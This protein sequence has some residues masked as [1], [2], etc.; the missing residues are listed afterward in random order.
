MSI[1][2]S[3]RG[4][5]SQQGTSAIEFAFVFPLL[6]AVTYAAIVYGYVFF[7]Q[8]TLNFLGQEAARNMVRVDPTTPG[9]SGVLAAAAT[10]SVNQSKAQLPLIGRDAIVT[11]VTP[12]IDPM[13]MP[14]RTVTVS[15]PIAALTTGG[16]F[17]SIPLPMNL[18][19]F[20]PLPTTLAASAVI[21]VN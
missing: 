11:T 18:G 16:G 20:P 3:R 21:R 13:G 19:T 4:R 1:R 14:T 6:F 9:Y 2:M 10:N 8:Q 12:G 5:T 15:M 7:V 17:A